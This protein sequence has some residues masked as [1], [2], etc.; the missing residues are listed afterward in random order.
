MKYLRD[1]TYVVG[2]YVVQ[3]DRVLLLWHGGLSRWVPSGGRIE[4]TS[5]E[6]PHEALIREVREETGLAVEVVGSTG[7]DVRDESV[8]PLPVPVAV[9]EIRIRASAEYLDFVY[10]CRAVAG[11]VSLDYHAARAYHWFSKAELDLFP[12]MPHVFTYATHALATLSG[13]TDASHA[14]VTRSDLSG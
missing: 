6:Y 9:Q 5:G 8:S 11:D 3:Q 2:G 14:S 7:I 10:F 13:G 4:L 1:A 12:L